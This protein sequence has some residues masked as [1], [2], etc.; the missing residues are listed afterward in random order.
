MEIHRSSARFA[1][2]PAP[3]L[4]NRRRAP[5]P[6]VV[7]RPSRPDPTDPT[8]PDPTRPDGMIALLTR[9]L[10]GAEAHRRRMPGW[11]S[12]P[13][14]ARDRMA[15]EAMALREAWQICKRPSNP[16]D[17][18]LQMGRQAKDPRAVQRRS[19]ARA[20]PPSGQWIAESFL[21]RVGTIRNMAAL[22]SLARRRSRAPHGRLVAALV[23]HR[24]RLVRPPRRRQ[25]YSRAHHRA[26]VLTG[27]RRCQDTLRDRR[28]PLPPRLRLRRLLLR[29][30]FWIRCW[31]LALV[32]SRAAPVST[33]ARR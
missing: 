13:E 4:T 27:A 23:P 32:V 22:S 14:R 30:V 15:A 20:G 28:R 5:L 19:Q 12:L 24:T 25:R 3:C 33:I 18:P 10:S 16:D 11:R 21:A 2:R 7:S 9:R 6:P 31:E 8:R 26:R 1:H 29:A 17:R